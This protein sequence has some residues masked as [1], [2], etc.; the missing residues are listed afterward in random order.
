MAPLSRS[1]GLLFVVALAACRPPDTSARGFDSTQVAVFRDPVVRLG[2][3]AADGKSV[4]RTRVLP[5][6]AVPDNV[7]PPFDL[8]RMDLQ[9]GVESLMAPAVLAFATV[10][11]ALSTSTPHDQSLALLRFGSA[12]EVPVAL[13]PEL[14][15]PLVLTFL[16]EVTGSQLDIAGVDSKNVHLGATRSDPI[17]V[18]KQGANGVLTPWSGTPEG[19]MPLP[20]GVNPV[21]RDRSGVVALTN[22]PAGGTQ[23][24]SRFPFDGSPPVVLAA[25]MSTDSTV[26]N[27]DEPA[28]R[29]LILP[30]SG[31][32]ARLSCPP[33]VSTDPPAAC[34]LFYDRVSS[35]M[36]SAGFV[37]L[38][39]EKVG[40]FQLPGNLLGH[41][42]DVARVAPDGH[43]MF[44]P[45][46]SSTK[47]MRLFTWKAGEPAAATCVAG[48]APATSTF[49][50]NAWRPG[51]PQFAVIAQPSSQSELAPAT[52]TAL[53]G[54]ASVECHVIATGNNLIKQLV[55]A[56]D[57]SRFAFLEVDPLGAS[58][59]YVADAEAPIPQV[60]AE[61]QTFV[62]LE[63][64]D[65]RHL[66]LART[67][68]D[69][70]ALSWLDVSKVPAQNHP[71]ADSVVWDART[72]WA[73]LNART[74]VLADVTSLED[75]SFSIHVVDIESGAQRLVS[76]GVVDLSMSWTKRP[77]DA[78]ELA[79][80]YVVRGRDESEQDGLWLAHI[81]LSEFPP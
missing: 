5:D 80:A 25:G 22:S 66:L 18:N 4:Y 57:G 52:W 41:V 24:L 28:S 46:L 31:V 19:L 37:R 15:P 64:H 79:V 16:D 77:D 2:P 55:Y 10:P 7:K 54:T 13:L 69:G 70:Y 76:R 33:K 1:H 12:A 72:S 42:G 67:T 44:W 81:G 39:D 17:L 61:G 35:D 58:K 8:T 30:S 63:F 51:R 3:F 45:A 75:S 49:T 50:M 6:V 32:V 56:P 9:T 36:S 29:R 40:E 53:A 47:Q 34:L 26:V 27:G 60:V 21:G 14:L 78:T 20:G 62:F 73:W 43:A 23:Q 71:I 38:V 11:L 59:V 65:A 68:T 48:Q 74:L